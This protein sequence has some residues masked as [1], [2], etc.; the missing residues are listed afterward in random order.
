MPQSR[1]R[2]ETLDFPVKTMLGREDFFV[3][4]SN[5]EAV[6]LIEN[7]SGAFSSLLIV[8][9]KGSGKTH[10]AHLFAAAVFEK[11]GEKPV[12][13][14]ELTLSAVEK[15]LDVS[16]FAVL[17]EVRSPVGEEALFH[18][19]NGVKNRGGVL[20]MTA[21]KN[22]PS[23]GI[24]LPDLISRLSAVPSAELG[25]PDDAL[26]SAVWVKFFAERGV[27]V[28]PDAVAYLLKNAERSFGF[29]AHV[30]AAADKKAL[31]EKRAVTIPLLK[32]VLKSIA[33]PLSR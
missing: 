18:L 26:M 29:A 15:A 17:D 19:M 31:S 7:P 2:Q 16:R 5:R 23:W 27:S 21:E 13:I 8:G 1:F 12:F 3:A 25:M 4:P 11:F 10:L 30:A 28:A 22:Y 33:A 6:A 9:P 20:L 32:D 14:S 24:R